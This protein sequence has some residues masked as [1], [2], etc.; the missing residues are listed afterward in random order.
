MGSGLGLAWLRE[1]FDSSVKGPLELA[2]IAPA[3]V[4]TAIPYI[5][6]RGERIGKRRRVV[7]IAGLAALVVG[8]VA[9]G[10][11]VFVKPLPALLESVLARVRLG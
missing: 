1:L 5:E 10:L 4:L 2:R 3:P 9:L 11:H 7:A 8:A 6:T